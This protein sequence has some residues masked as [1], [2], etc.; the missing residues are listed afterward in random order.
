VIRGPDFIRAPGHHM[1]GRK[2]SKPRTQKKGGS[3]G[4]GGQH[5]R[6]DISLIKK[7]AR[8][9]R[10]RPYSEAATKLHW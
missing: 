4:S 10:S 8:E 1:L 6:Q 3:E 9:D 5:D 2:R 7:K